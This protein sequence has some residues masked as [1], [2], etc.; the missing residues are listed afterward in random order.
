M[1]SITKMPST[2]RSSLKIAASVL[3]AVPLLAMLSG[4]GRNAAPVKLSTSET[5]LA[6]K[7]VTKG[8]DVP[9]YPDDDPSTA[10]GKVVYEKMNCA[11]CHGAD[12]S[13]EVGERDMAVT[14][15][16]GTEQTKKMKVVLSDK[17]FMRNL[18]PVDQYMFV[19]FGKLPDGTQLSE[20]KH[21]RA[22]NHM[23]RR[24]AWALV[25][26]TRALAVQPLNDKEIDDVDIVFKAN[27][28]VCHGGKGYGDG[29][30]AHNLEPKPA[31]FQQFPRFYDRT[32]A[33]LWDHIANGIKWEGMPNFLNKEDRQK[34]PPV[35]FDQEYIWKLVN[36]VRHFQ[37]TTK[38]TLAVNGVQPAETK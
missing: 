27:C 1:Q 3:L 7:D 16:D 37:E 32:D 20:E 29:P 38:P 13:K 26:H 28:A 36:Y 19:A 30:L 24:E 33:V 34:K 9:V 4:C 17:D 2:L 21:P 25:M 22:L 14:M 6:T 8:V 10:D 15:A 18:K 12:G 35:K 23:S 31:N 11:Q 5:E